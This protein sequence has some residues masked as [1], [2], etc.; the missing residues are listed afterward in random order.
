MRLGDKA[1]EGGDIVSGLLKSDLLLVMDHSLASSWNDAVEEGTKQGVV[2]GALLRVIH[3]MRA[4]DVEEPSLNK[5]VKIY[6]DFAL[7]RKYGQTEK[8]L[9]YS[10]QTILNCWYASRSVAHYWAALEYAKTQ[11]SP[12]EG[13][14]EEIFRSRNDFQKFILI[15]GHMAKFA[16]EFVPKRAKPPHPLVPIK[17]QVREG[18]AGP[19]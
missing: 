11:N 7:G 9:P 3:D 1:D 8:P 10:R 15:A 13:P 18:L 5:A 16:A 19:V 12:Y 6:M 4:A 17:E 14:R 2:A